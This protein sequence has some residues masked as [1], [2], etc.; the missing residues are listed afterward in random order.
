MAAVEEETNEGAT[1]AA[2]DRDEVVMELEDFASPMGEG[3][4]A[5]AEHQP[6][7]AAEG[8]KGPE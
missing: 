8:M 6:I 3:G 7:A 2:C 4:H 1:P 5:T